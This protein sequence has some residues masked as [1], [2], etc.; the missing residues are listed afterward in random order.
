MTPSGPQGRVRRCRELAGD[1][2]RGERELSL[3]TKPDGR[4]SLT[5]EFPFYLP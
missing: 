2:P 4:A 3:G 5:A 1:R